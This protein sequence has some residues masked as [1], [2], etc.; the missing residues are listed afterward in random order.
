MRRAARFV[1]ASIGICLG[2]IGPVVAQA[3]APRTGT[4]KVVTLAYS[5]VGPDESDHAW[6]GVRVKLMRAGAAHAD[7]A[8][9]DAYG[10]ARFARVRPGL[11]SV[12]AQGFALQADGGSRAVEERSRK[13]FRVLRGHTVAETLRIVGIPDPKGSLYKREAFK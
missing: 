7:T 8:T 3:Q 11:Y 6:P 12:L 9:T 4:V 2:A 13:P 1:A 5:L 10:R